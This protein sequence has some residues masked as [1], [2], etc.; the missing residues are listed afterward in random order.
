MSHHLGTVEV[1]MVGPLL[2]LA[3]RLGVAPTDTI[4]AAAIGRLVDE[5]VVEDDRIDFKKSM[6]PVN[7]HGRNELAKDVAAFANHRGGLGHRRRQ[8]AGRARSLHPLLEDP[9]L[10]LPSRVRRETG[11]SR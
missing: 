2:P 8:T 11:S 7:D 10:V 3:L 4:Q 6:Y 5:D 1:V 9:A